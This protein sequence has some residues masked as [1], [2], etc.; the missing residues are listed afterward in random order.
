MSKC[1]RTLQIP[2][3]NLGVNSWNLRDRV[4]CETQPVQKRE[5]GAVMDSCLHDMDSAMTLSSAA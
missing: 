3:P 4:C 1:K 2:G 5:E